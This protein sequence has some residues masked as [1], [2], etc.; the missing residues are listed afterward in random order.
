MRAILCCC[1]LP[2]P[3]PMPGAQV[4][5]ALYSYCKGTDAAYTEKAKALKYNI[6][7]NKELREG[8]L[9]QEV[10]ADTLVQKKSTDLA[11]RNK[12]SQR[13]T[14]KK[15]SL[16][17]TVC[18]DELKSLQNAAAGLEM[19]KTDAGLAVV[20]TTAE[21]AKK[22]E[23][24]R[25]RRKAE[26]ERSRAAAAAL[27]KQQQ[28]Y[29]KVAVTNDEEYVQSTWEY[30]PK[31]NGRGNEDSD[32]EDAQK[33]TE[34]VIDSPVLTAQPLDGIEM[35]PL[36]GTDGLGDGG[37]FAGAVWEGELDCRSTK[38]ALL[39]PEQA[40]A[41]PFKL[42][43][44][45]LQ[46]EGALHNPIH[47][48]LHVQGYI[49]LVDMEKYIEA[50]RKTP[51]VKMVLAFKMLPRPRDRVRYD[52]LLE[53]MTNKKKGMCVI[54]DRNWGGLLYALPST[55]PSA[56]SLLPY[57][58][59]DCLVAIAITDR[60]K[61]EPPPRRQQP[62]DIHQDVTN[63]I[64]K[65]NTSMEKTVF[66][67]LKKSSVNLRL[68]AIAGDNELN[69]IPN[70]L[71][72]LSKCAVGDVINFLLTQKVSVME[73]E[74]E[75]ET[76]EEEHV[77]LIEHLVAKQRA[78]VVVDT[79]TALLYLIPPVDEAGKL[80]DPPSTSC[81][82][83]L[84]VLLLSDTS[85]GAG[86]DSSAQSMPDLGF[87]AQDFTAAPVAPVQ[88]Q[89][90]VISA[91]NSVPTHGKERGGELAKDASHSMP[92]S[93]HMHHARA[94]DPV[95]VQQMGL[96]GAQASP[97]AASPRP[98]YDSL[99]SPGISAPRSHAAPL[100][101]APA[102]PSRPA[103]ALPSSAHGAARGWN[104]GPQ[105]EP[106]GG[107]KGWQ[108]RSAYHGQGPGAAGPGGGGVPGRFLGDQQRDDR[109]W[110]SRN[111]PP[112]P[113]N[114]PQNFPPY[115]MGGRMGGGMGAGM[116]GG[117]RDAPYS[118]G[119]GNGN[120]YGGW[121][122]SGGMG[123]MGMGNMGRAPGPNNP[124]YSSWGPGDRPSGDPRNFRR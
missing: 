37:D 35:E 110:H 53:E 51:E 99:Q 19:R 109:Q 94:P 65:A 27:Q 73:V 104:A 13:E 8:I 82:N 26:E 48:K 44:F 72:D 102:P 70:D 22:E 62:D 119:G 15:E 91:G 56:S 6:A 12:K 60:K 63:D 28:T 86:Q 66:L 34:L 97:Y 29:I 61:K 75:R 40:N 95:S 90:P 14:A 74:P 108:D 21:K 115:P 81:D 47:S 36:E 39:Y 67:K 59:D 100:H 18:N 52:T 124:P 123:N 113:S 24:E 45:P 96:G 93:T 106:M 50:K 103:P 32:D 3:K 38:R 54:D 5:E 9:S 64:A 98:A 2:A 117:Q 121:N 23:E 49:S 80:L 55:S 84:A 85:A 31:A 83:M 101:P 25:E 68:R 16:Q 112:F 118:Q 92:N 107:G 78:S 120:A 116:G 89:E 46:D 77:K 58:E 88:P 20:D 1:C 17:E 4:E 41:P 79:K 114:Q 10:D 69:Q 71:E 76:D 57:G 30:T 7:N 111:G 42:A 122:G 33:D 43:A 87:Q 105:R 11:D